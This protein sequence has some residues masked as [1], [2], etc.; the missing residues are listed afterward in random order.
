VTFAAR[1]FSVGDRPVH[2]RAASQP[3]PTGCHMIV[4]NTYLQAL[5][6]SLGG[7]HTTDLKRSMWD[8][9]QNP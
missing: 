1:P 8:L 4:T 7:N 3:L 5:P 2:C 6:V 9:P